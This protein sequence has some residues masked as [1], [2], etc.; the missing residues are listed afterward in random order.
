MEALLHRLRH[1]PEM[2]PIVLTFHFLS[3]ANIE[4]HAELETSV[5]ELQQRIEAD[6]PIGLYRLLKLT[7]GG[8]LVPQD[9]TVQQLLGPI[10]SGEQLSAII[11]QDVSVNAPWVGQANTH[12]DYDSCFRQARVGRGWATVGPFPNCDLTVPSE[13]G[14]QSSPWVYSIVT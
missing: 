10:A 5:P 2:E 11:V 14:P 8:L 1:P 6:Y 9:F 4:I 3:G 7:V 12:Q 13:G